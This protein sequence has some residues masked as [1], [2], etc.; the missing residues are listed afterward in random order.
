MIEEIG[1]E[2][3]KK[4]GGFVAVNVSCCCGVVYRFLFFLLSL[5]FFS[6]LVVVRKLTMFIFAVEQARMIKGVDLDKLD[7]VKF[8]GWNKLQP[9]YEG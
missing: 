7:L 1:K 6:I 4:E 3:V 8:D 9:Q 5:F 2:G